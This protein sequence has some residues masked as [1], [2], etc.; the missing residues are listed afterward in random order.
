MKI[1]PKDSDMMRFANKVQLPDDLNDTVPCWLWQGAQHSKHRGYGK[2]RYQGKPMNAHKASYLMFHGA[3]PQ[4]M[5]IGHQCN[6][7]QCVSP[8]HLKAESQSDNMKFCVFSGRHGSH[9]RARLATEIRM[10]LAHEETLKD[11]NFSWDDIEP[12]AF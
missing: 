12:L 5:V 10:Y 8:H 3:V 2:F 4:G 9:K 1:D 11:I 7:E 6:N